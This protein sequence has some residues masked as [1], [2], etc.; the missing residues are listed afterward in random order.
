MRVYSE[1]ESFC[2]LS[3][4]GPLM[5]EGVNLESDITPFSMRKDSRS[6]VKKSSPRASV[7]RTKLLINSP[8]L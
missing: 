6:E 3:L 2:W 1:S 5:M 4:A 8:P 7:K